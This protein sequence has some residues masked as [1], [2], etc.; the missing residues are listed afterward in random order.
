MV[1]LN[2]TLVSHFVLVTPLT[3]LAGLQE[4]QQKRS[5]R[6]LKHGKRKP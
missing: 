2:V 3:V 1:C 6:V 5:L 4:L